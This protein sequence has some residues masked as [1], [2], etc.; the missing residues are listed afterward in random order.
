MNFIYK[1]GI[2]NLSSLT[3]NDTKK[4]FVTFLTLTW[5]KYV[6]KLVGVRHPALFSHFFTGLDKPRANK[7]LSNLPL[8]DKMRQQC[9]NR[10]EKL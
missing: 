2:R 8:T 3:V 5:F 10:I 6:F 1:G 9:L 7:R 4:Y